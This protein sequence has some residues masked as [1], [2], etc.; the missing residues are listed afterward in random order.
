M[1]EA[2][3][4]IHDDDD[5]NVEQYI[6]V[7]ETVHHGF[8]ITDSRLRRLQWILGLVMVSHVL[9]LAV[10]LVHRRDELALSRILVV[11]GTFAVLYSV[12]LC[13]IVQKWNP[14]LLR[15]QQINNGFFVLTYKETDDCMSWQ[16]HWRI[17]YSGNYKSIELSQMEGIQTMEGTTSKHPS[18]LVATPV[19]PNMGGITILRTDRETVDF[20]FER[21]LPYV[22]GSG[23]P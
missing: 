22:A 2:G 23:P 6:T 16:Y 3:Y 1:T 7:T 13:Y 8:D 12:L 20:C 14:L 15:L 17:L 5:N 10:K 18:R 4:K 9:L 21:L 11:L 19:D